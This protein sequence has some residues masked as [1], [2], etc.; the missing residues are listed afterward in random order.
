MTGPVN[1]HRYVAVVG[2]ANM[3]LVATMERVPAPGETVGGTRFDTFPGG[4]GANQAVSVARLGG[5][6]V[7]LGKVGR[8]AFGD[9]L[10]DSMSAA[11]V[12]T[13]LVG[14]VNDESTGIAVILVD[15]SGENRI[16]VVKGANGRLCSSDVDAAADAIASAG[17]LLVQLEIP[18]EAVQ[19]AVEIAHRAGARVILDPAPMPSDPLPD[20]LLARVDIITPNQLEASALTGLAR[21]ETESDAQLAGLRLL[22][23]GVGTAVVKLGAGGAVVVAP[24]REPVRI[25]G[26][27]VTAVDT[28]AAGDT[29]AGALAVAA[30]EGLDPV[31]GV[32]FANA[33][34]AISVQRLGAQS[35]MPTRAEVEAF[36]EGVAPGEQRPM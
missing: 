19:R 23:K 10:L 18:F 8:D 16:V 25:H 13:D 28:T 7:F 22:E 32:E 31:H 4:K 26:H 5:D 36:L 12:R 6:C 17:A 34:A 33:A 20:S 35:S 9:R 11:G 14:R 27:K 2:S 1:R 30:V 29:F 24:G 3:D 15:R 21:V